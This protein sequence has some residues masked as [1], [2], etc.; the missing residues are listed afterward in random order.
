[1]TLYSSGSTCNLYSYVKTRA[2]ARAVVHGSLVLQD[3]IRA[4]ESP[5]PT[6]PR[7]LPGPAAADVPTPVPVAPMST[8]TRLWSDQNKKVLTLDTINCTLPWRMQRTK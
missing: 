6:Q 4:V 7:P 3:E 1:M 5:M 8:P 2:L